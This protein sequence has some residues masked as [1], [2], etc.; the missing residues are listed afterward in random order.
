MSFLLSALLW[1]TA[2]SAAGPA[3]TASPVATPE[4]NLAGTMPL[5]LTGD[6]L[7]EFESYI[8]QSMTALGVPGASI[9]VVQGGKIVYMNGFGVRDMR[10]NAPVTPDTLLMIGSVNKS[11]TS[12]LA[13]TLVDAGSLSWD[14][15]VV[16]VLPEFAVSDPAMTPKLTVADAFCACTGLP[17]HDAELIFN[18]DSLTPEKMIE[19]IANY[20]LTA[21]LGQEFQYS[22]QMYAIGGYAAA[23]AAGANPNDLTAGYRQVMQDRILNPIGMTRSTFSLDE[24]LTS[25]DYAASYA[26]NLDGSTVPMSLLSEADF[27]SAVAPAGALWSSARDM[28]A[29]LQTQLAD[30][31]A[32]NGT[33]AVS[34]A[35]LERTHQGRVKIVPQPDEPPL[36]SDSSQA[37]AM[38]WVT[39]TYKGQPMISHNGGT[40]GFVS[41]LAFLP[42]ANLGLVILTN[43]TAGAGAFTTAVQY[44]LFEL[45]FNQ[46][47]EIDP[48]LQQY[49]SAAGQQGPQLG[50]LDPS[51]V[52]P[53]LGRYTNPALG[54]IAL[55]MQGDRLILDGGEVRSGL[56]PVMDESGKM[57]GYTFSDAP[58]TEASV[59]VSLDQGDNGRP[60]VLV[61]VMGE[62]AETYVFTA[63]A[64][65]SMA[66]PSP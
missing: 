39:G 63:T 57:L 22:N 34:A 2:G 36:L 25:G 3:Q 19:S 65:G 24:V 15:P 44:R 27:V 35:N 53:Y 64:A 48:L 4:V 62:G 60:E 55:R 38:G 14:R 21:P 12:M 17:R 43:G 52:A 29:Y 59:L 26:S 18:F 8:Q 58:L 6:R 51:A 50:Q 5:D 20:P 28:A 9:A 46:P 7:A 32:P 1:L 45:L 13:A 11:F 31:V 16:D 10:S 23:V 33:Q 56:V 49:M 54:D 42:D 47:A 41:E 66:T 30:G 61:N 40:L 37:Y